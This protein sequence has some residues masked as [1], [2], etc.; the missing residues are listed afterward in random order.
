MMIHELKITT[1]PSLD[2]R[3]G[4]KRVEI[5]KNDRLPRFQVGD[6]LLLREVCDKPTTGLL[7]YGLI[8]TG[9]LEVRRITHITHGPLYNGGSAGLEEGYVA[10]S[11]APIETSK[12]EDDGAIDL[13]KITARDR[14]F[15]E[16]RKGLERQIAADQDADDQDRRTA[17]HVAE[18]IE[19]HVRGPARDP[20][21]NVED[22]QRL[23]ALHR[24]DLHDRRGS[25]PDRRENVD[26]T[27]RGRL[28]GRR[29]GRGRRK[30]DP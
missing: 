4:R 19:S 29:S 11:I 20:I 26:G 3:D 2:V 25:I 27:R 13:P 8:P 12:H 10:L 9:H 22:E 14:E 21:P 15:I 6:V 24:R 28:K 16:A 5:R 23:R 17:A 30:L 1:R 18:A 7:Q